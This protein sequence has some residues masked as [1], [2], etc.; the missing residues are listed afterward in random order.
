MALTAD[1]FLTIMAPGI[2]VASGASTSAV[3][4][5]PK[6]LGNSNFPTK[7][8][9]RATQAAS[10]R[11]GVA[12]VV[13]TAND[14]MVQPGDAVRLRVPLGVTSFAVIQQT[15][16]GVVQVSPVEDI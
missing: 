1:D 15:T 13:A 10:I 3:T 4:A 7:I 8:I 6:T 12:G 5:I 16:A 14:T 9:V 2:S 11:L